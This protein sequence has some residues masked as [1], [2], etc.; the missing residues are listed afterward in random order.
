VGETVDQGHL[1]L[2]HRR[3]GHAIRPNVLLSAFRYGTHS[4]QVMQSVPN[5]G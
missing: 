2:A 3:L 4:L 1:E 5:L